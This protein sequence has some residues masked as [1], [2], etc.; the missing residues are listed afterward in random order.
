MLF[1]VI[2]KMSDNKNYLAS[3]N[4]FLMCVLLLLWLCVTMLQ[5]ALLFV[6]A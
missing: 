1:K 3:V 4:A 5:L 6:R 2:H